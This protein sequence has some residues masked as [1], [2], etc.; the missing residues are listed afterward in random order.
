[1]KFAKKLRQLGDIAGDP[2]RLI[3]AEQAWRQNTGQAASN[4][5]AA[6]SALSSGRVLKAMAAAGA[7]LWTAFT[8]ASKSVKALGR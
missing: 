7:A 2:L 5:R 6:A 1:M 4:R 8:T 3:L